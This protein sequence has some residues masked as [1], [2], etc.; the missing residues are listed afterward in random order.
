MIEHGPPTNQTQPY[1]NNKKGGAL[2]VQLI[3]GYRGL[4]KLVEQSS[5]ARITPPM[6][7][8][9]NDVFTYQYGDKQF[10]KHTPATGERGKLIYV[11]ALVR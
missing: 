9:E 6:A 3:P 1:K 10:L 8:Y 4:M 11:Y 2:E 5:R 7:V